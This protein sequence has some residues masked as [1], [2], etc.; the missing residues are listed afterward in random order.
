MVLFLDIIIRLIWKRR[1][2]TPLFTDDEFVVDNGK[3]DVLPNL[4]LPN[5]SIHDQNMAA[6]GENHETLPVYSPAVPKTKIR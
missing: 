6:I 1:H 4:Q 2:T 3:M 5:Q